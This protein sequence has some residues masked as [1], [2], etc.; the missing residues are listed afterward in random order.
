[1]DNSKECESDDHLEETNLEDLE[2]DELKN[3]VVGTQA[4]DKH[5]SDFSEEGNVLKNEM[6]V[7]FE[8]ESE[9]LK[10]F[11]TEE[12]H[13]KT[14]GPFI[15]IEIRMKEGFQH[16]IERKERKEWKKCANYYS[17]YTDWYNDIAKEMSNDKIYLSHKDYVFFSKSMV[18]A[19]KKEFTFDMTKKHWAN[20]NI[21]YVL[22]LHPKDET[23]PK[24]VMDRK[25]D[26]DTHQPINKWE[27]DEVSDEFYSEHKEL[28]ICA[29]NKKKKESYWDKVRVNVLSNVGKIFKK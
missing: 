7:D 25:S 20:Y 5:L 16:F 4:D 18:S 12:S 10:K 9:A 2:E 27:L 11:Q 28:V 21:D 24:Q 13:E 15:K 3:E 26:R 17:S 29:L 6:E 1:M 19:K 8:A 14:T 22:I 23:K